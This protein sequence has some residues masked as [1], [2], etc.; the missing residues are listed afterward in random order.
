MKKYEITDI[1]HPLHSQLHRIKALCSFRKAVQAGQLGG[2]VQSEGNLSQEGSCWI[3]DDAIAME[4]AIVTQEAV[5]KDHATAMGHGHLGGT[6]V[7]E[8]HAL[9]CGH[10]IATGGLLTGVC[11]AGEDANIHPDE[12]TGAAPVLSG[13]AKVYGEVSGFVQCCGNAVILPGM[14]LNN[15]AKDVVIISQADFQTKAPWNHSSPCVASPPD[16]D[17]R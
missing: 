10:A 17:E 14:V 8:D 5:M 15:P 6:A 12:K 9:I 11:M 1:V 7:C 2:F 3:F 4:N 16:R 13:Y